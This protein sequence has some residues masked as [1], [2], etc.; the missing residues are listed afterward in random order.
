MAPAHLIRLSLV[1]LLLLTAPAQAGF[2]GDGGRDLHLRSSL[3]V[4]GAIRGYKLTSTH[5]R[6]VV[7]KL[8][9]PADLAAPLTLPAGPWAELTLLL[10]GPVTVS[11]GETSLR[12]EVDTLT[13]SLTDPD[14]RQ[15]HL[16][17][18]LPEPLLA[19]IQR[20]D[21]APLL[22]TALQDGAVAAP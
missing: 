13:V 6:T 21:V 12:L 17:W 19:Q 1:G 7:V 2:W 15:V 9:T 5:G 4:T 14:A 8:A 11:A 16:E 22:L 18:S 10:D 3:Q 20:P